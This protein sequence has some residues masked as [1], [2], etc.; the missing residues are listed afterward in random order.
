MSLVGDGITRL[1]YTFFESTSI[2]VH[3]G[4]SR[5]LGDI[6]LEAPPIVHRVTWGR[7][8][9]PL[10]ACMKELHRMRRYSSFPSTIVPKTHSYS[11]L[12]TI[13]DDSHFMNSIPL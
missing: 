1:A 2:H 3:H 5:N 8:I 9:E 12:I 13:C 10:L 6:L 4:R 11:V 7:M